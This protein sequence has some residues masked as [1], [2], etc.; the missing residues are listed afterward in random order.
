MLA[1]ESSP[2]RGEVYITATKDVPNAEN[3]RFT[4]TFLTKVFDGPYNS[5]PK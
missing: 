4:G 2:W 5:I 3:V 1:A